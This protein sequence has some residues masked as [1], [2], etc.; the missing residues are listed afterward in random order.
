MRVLVTY[1]SK[2]GGTEGLALAVA[3]QLRADGLEIDLAAAEHAP[4]P[5]PYDAVVV[6][7]ALYENRW[8]RAAAHYVR[9][10]HHVLA[11]RPTYFFSSGPLGDRYVDRNAPMVP[12]V[13]YLSSLVDFR[14]HHTFGGRLLPDAHGY[15]AHSMAQC[16]AGDWRDAAQARRWADE[17]AAALG[18]RPGGG[19]PAVKWARP[20]PD[21]PGDAVRPRPAS[22]RGP[23]RP[24]HC[25]TAAPGATGR[26][27]APVPRGP[28]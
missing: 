15:M 18:C 20:G 14:G 24:G 6:G 19:A 3:E 9:H 5:G 26:P 12:Q 17:I 25:G 11:G 28:R 7:G 16:L 22:G 13:S 21:R 23:E 4:S 1:G 8:H 10:H 2:R 27:G